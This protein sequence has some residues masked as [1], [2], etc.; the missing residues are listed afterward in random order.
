[1]R[2]QNNIIVYRKRNAELEERNM[3]ST[4]KHGG[5]GRMVWGCMV[6]LGVGN[7]VAINS[8]MDH[9]YYI[10]ILKETGNRGVP[11]LPNQLTQTLCSQYKAL[12][13]PCNYPKVIKTPSLSP[14]I[15]PIEHLR[16]IFEKT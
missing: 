5:K 6:T 15:N 2:W 12:F 8:I 14:D 13:A 16:S 10:Q 3:M 4:V 7:T 9:L 11:V 1:M